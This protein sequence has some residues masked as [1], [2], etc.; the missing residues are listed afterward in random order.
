MQNYSEPNVKNKSQTG[1]DQSRH[2][3]INLGKS[4]CTGPQCINQDET[5][6]IEIIQTQARAIKNNW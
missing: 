2:I 1:L 6:T 3:R 4:Y 5:R